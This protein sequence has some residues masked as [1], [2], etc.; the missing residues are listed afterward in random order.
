[1]YIQNKHFRVTPWMTHLF[2]L[3]LFLFTTLAATV[4]AENQK[5]EPIAVIVNRGNSVESL[6]K[7]D[8]ARIYKGK[9]KNW[10][11]GAKIATINRPIN[12]AIRRKFYDII[13]NSSPTEK[14]FTS[15]SPLPFKSMLV[16]SDSA[17]L[18]FVMRMSNAIGYIPLSRVNDSVKVLAIDNTKADNGDYPLK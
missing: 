3:T 7:V 6:S 15:G 4:A 9:K 5:S 13:L 14:F 18:K 12:S 17:T 10:K 8:L 16:K 1:M 2:T 11:N